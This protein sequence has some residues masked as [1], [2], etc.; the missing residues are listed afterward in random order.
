LNQRGVHWNSEYPTKLVRDGSDFLNLQQVDRHWVIQTTTYGSFATNS[1]L[2]PQAQVTA[3]QMYRN[4]AHVS[5]EVIAHVQ[6]A[7]RDTVVDGTI[8]ALNTIQCETCSVS[9]ATEQISRS[10]ETEDL[11]NGLPFDRCG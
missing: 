3:E 7:S 4:L 5:P 6:K 11:T 10:T 1:K 8:P 9:K 2:A